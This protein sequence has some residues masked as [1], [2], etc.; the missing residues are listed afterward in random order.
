MPLPVVG[1]V[2]YFLGTQSPLES[3]KKLQQNYGDIVTI[4]VGHSTKVI[5]VIGYKEVASLFGSK[6]FA[7][8]TADR[9]GGISDARELAKG[10]LWAGWP[11]VQERR[12]FVIRWL[13][14]FGLT[15]SGNKQALTTD[16]LEDEV[17][18]LC[19]FVEKSCG[20]PIDL[21][22]RISEYSSSCVLVPLRGTPLDLEDPQ[23]KVMF[24]AGEEFFKT[25]FQSILLAPFASML[26]FM[27]PDTMKK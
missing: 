26:K 25:T 24:E 27:V 15:I 13:K 9:P 5:F 3:F 14:E 6:E 22:K 19:S 11:T 10:I 7:E 8:L 2:N 1:N 18:S 20:K 23:T 17:L 12:K 16:R 4:H 21:S